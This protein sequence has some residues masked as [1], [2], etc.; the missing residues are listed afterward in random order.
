MFHRRRARK[1][2]VKVTPGLTLPDWVSASFLPASG[3]VGV[4]R[5]SES[6]EAW[7]PGLDAEALW[8]TVC[9]HYAW[10]CL[11]LFPGIGLKKK[12]KQKHCL[13]YL[14]STLCCRPI[15][16]PSS[17]CFLALCVEY[18][19]WEQLCVCV[20]VCVCVHARIHARV[21]MNLCM[22]TWYPIKMVQASEFGNTGI[23]KVW[24]S[25]YARLKF[26]KSSSKL[27]VFS[28]GAAG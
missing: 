4:L 26:L 19:F 10:Y 12:N 25:E 20:C 6:G 22:S 3:P 2:K 9:V 16:L 1:V 15:L 27:L 24:I 5:G 13:P 11:T 23:L 14:T 17:W 18:W 21:S 8:A 28:C 7:E